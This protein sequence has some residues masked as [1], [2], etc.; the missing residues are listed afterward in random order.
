MR[1]TGRVLVA[2]DPLL[3][4]ALSA[5]AWGAAGGAVGLAWARASDTRVMRPRAVLRLRQWETREAYRRATRVHRWK[6]WVPDAGAW[7]GG[8]RKR[9]ADAGGTGPDA[10]A[11]VAI[12]VTRAELVHWTMLAIAPAWITWSRGWVLAC[13]AAFALA[14]NAPCI[15]VTRSTRAR[16]AAVA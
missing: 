1:H 13:N 6:R 2:L 14:I 9:L 15:V 8:R 4:L 16:L 11:R 5:A 12:E 7:C 10:R 3:A